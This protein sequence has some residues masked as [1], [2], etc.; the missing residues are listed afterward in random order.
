MPKGQQGAH[1]FDCLAPRLKRIINTRVA[2]ATQHTRTAPTLKELWDLLE[3]HLHEYDPS[4]ADER[5][6]ALTPRVVKGQVTRIDLEGFYACW[7]WLLPFSTATRLQVIL[8]KIPWIKE[9]VVKKETENSQGSYV[10]DFSGLDPLAGRARIE[11]KVRKYSAQRCI[12]VP[13][14]VS[15]SKPRV[16]VDCKDLYV[17]EWILQLNNTRH[18]RGYTMKVEQR[19]PRLKPEDIYTLAHKDVP[20][21][22]ALNRLNK[23][24]RTMVTYTHRPSHNRTAVNAVN[25]NATA[26]PN[27]AA[28]TDI[29]LNAVGHPKHPAKTTVDPRPKPP[30]SFWVRCSKH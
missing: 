1:D 8:K 19:R 10:V 2:K 21:R 4:R 20:E 15:Y 9:K 11:K 17:Q 25:A 29:S 3:Q 27:T 6:P 23:G 24:E 7:Q 5:W 13:E 26:D 22:E 16:I 30:P 14:I 18:T 12:T 28:P